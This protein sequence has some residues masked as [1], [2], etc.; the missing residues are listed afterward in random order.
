MFKLV[1]QDDEGKTTVVP[2]IRDEIT[3]GRKDSMVATPTP[4]GIPP[5]QMWTALNSSPVT[6]E[7]SRIAAIRMNIGTEASTNSLMKL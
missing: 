7:R 2:L 1:I 4:P 5:A 6:P 3:I